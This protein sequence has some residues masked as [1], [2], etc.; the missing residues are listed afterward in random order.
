MDKNARLIL[1]FSALASLAL[2]VSLASAQNF[3]P[4]TVVETGQRFAR[5][6]EAV[7]AIG[8]GTGT[9]RI[10][11][12]RHAD[13]AVQGAGSITYQAETPGQA[14]FDSVACEGK[15]VLVLRG[16][17]ARVEGLVFA[18][19]RVADFNGV[20]IRIE[21]GNL[22]VSQSWFRDS[23]QGILGGIDTRSR[24]SID[25]STFT[26]L[27]TCEGPGGCAHS[28]YIG[29][30]GSVSITRSRFEQGRGGHYAKSRSR[31]IE[32]VGNSFDDSGGRGTNYMIDLPG[33][34]SGRIASNWF[35]QGQDKEN[36]SAFITV[37]PEGKQYSSA[38]LVIE[39]NDARFAPGVSRTSTFVANWSDDPVQ[40]GANYLAPGIKRSDRR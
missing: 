28:V 25:K 8:G 14:I 37:A 23:Q 21:L 17:N 6:Q 9:I 34:A 33:G 20:G 38:G 13:C 39:N 15:G 12:G 7:Q 10:A 35:V 19:I 4:Y 2:P 1:A 11:N 18:N 31:T 29:D 5:L 27:G 3:T 36:W 24:I 26:R 16:D 22:E 32:I 30:Y 40:I